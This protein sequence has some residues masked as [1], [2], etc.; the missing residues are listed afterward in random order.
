MPVKLL[1]DCD[2]GVDDAVALLLAAGH[3]DAEVLAITTVAGNQTLEKVTLNARRIAT[4][5]GLDGVPVAAGAD[6]PLVRDQIMAAEVHGETGLDGPAYFEPTVPLADTNGV[7]LIIDTVMSR[8][9]EV[10]L[11]PIGPLT[12]IAAA[13]RRE[14]RLVEAVAGVVIMGGSYTRGNT[15]AAAEFNILADPEAAAI[16]FSARWP[17]TMVGLD[18]THQARATDAV[19][20]RIM[21][22]DTAPGR[23]VVDLL[24][25]A[26]KR[27]VALGWGSELALHDACAVAYAI[28][29]TLMT[30]QTAHVV[31][32]LK[33]EH[34]YGMTVT[35]FRGRS[36]AANTNVPQELD[37][38]RF[39]SMLVHSLERVPDYA[40]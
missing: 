6:R 8:P 2:P 7:D 25:A 3:P 9:G 40:G 32:E 4:I 27:M 33:G 39:W 5:A 11:V 24:R 30:G 31:V 13:L 15:T 22:L 1:I 18:L 19:I 14:P 29:P 37:A 28:D 36:G 26:Q 16:V 38:D 23:F 21:A 10:T 35:D 17:L 12:N 20:D 34:T